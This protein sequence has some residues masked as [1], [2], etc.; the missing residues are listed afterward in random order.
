MSEELCVEVLAATGNDTLLMLLLGAF[1]LFVAAGTVL[2]LRAKRLKRAAPALFLIPIVAGVLMLGTIP[3]PA[4]AATGGM[5]CVSE[6]PPAQAP[7]PTPNPDPAPLPSP[8]PGDPVCD[9]GE[10]LVDGVCVTDPVVCADGESLVDGECVVDPIECAE[11]EVLVNGVCEPLPVECPEGQVLIDGVC[12]DEIPECEPGQVLID[13]ICVD[14]PMPC[15][16]NEVY[17]NA[18]DSPTGVPGCF[19]KDGYIRENGVCVRAFAAREAQDQFTP[20]DAPVRLEVP[21]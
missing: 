19:C 10:T 15:R 1:L 16:S 11:G 4:L 18:D 20:E 17:L 3:T 21:A 6:T 5:E 9:S 14:G 2:L 7:A 13:G 12:V 8:S